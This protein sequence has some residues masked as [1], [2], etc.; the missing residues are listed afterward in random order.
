MST[1][2]NVISVPVSPTIIRSMESDVI[3]VPVSPTVIHSTASDVIF[4][5]VSPTSI[6][7]TAS[8]V[9]YVPVVSPTIRSTASDAVSGL[10]S[11]TTNLPTASNV[12]FVP[13]SPTT[14]STVS[15]VASVPVKD[16]VSSASSIDK[17][18]SSAEL[19]STPAKDGS[20]LKDATSSTAPLIS[21]SDKDEPSINTKLIYSSNSARDEDK[22]SLTSNNP[23]VLDKDKIHTTRYSTLLTSVPNKDKDEISS[24]TITGSLAISVPD[25]DKDTSTPSISKKASIPITSDFIATSISDRKYCTS[26]LIAHNV[27]GGVVLGSVATNVT[28]KDKINSTVWS[29]YKTSRAIGSCL[30]S[31]Q[32]S[33]AIT[34]SP[35][36]IDIPDKDKYT[37]T[38]SE[39]DIAVL[40]DSTATSIQGGNQPTSTI[41]ISDKF[42]IA[43]ISS[44]LVIDTPNKDK[45]KDTTIPATSTSNRGDKTDTY[46]PS[47]PTSQTVSDEDKSALTAVAIK[48]K[49]DSTKAT[50]SSTSVPAG[51]RFRSKAPFLN[52]TSTVIP[53]WT[54]A[55]LGNAYGGGYVS[56]PSIFVTSFPDSPRPSPGIPP[57]YELSSEDFQTPKYTPTSVGIGVQKKTSAGVNITRLNGL[58]ASGKGGNNS[59]VLAL[60]PTSIP[61]FQGLATLKHTMGFTTALVGVS[62]LIFFL[63]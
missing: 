6:S 11:S 30:I 3:S 4:V 39:S 19:K 12:V 17:E 46:T 55:L 31:D 34:S 38:T 26:I 58:S 9:V 45:D 40:F 56:T 49:L 21:L 54:P 41:S 42:S 32:A 63:L 20:R 2:S 59:V 27:S 44:S 62:V 10:V 5:P 7:P 24:A 25:K 18:S 53:I 37:L 14:V 43:V 16:E 57:G 50:P 22:V 48:E 15:S 61:E 28:N 29:Y 36:V 13:V 47:N 8:H 1:D 51:S 23:T 35:V 60:S 52:T 33:V